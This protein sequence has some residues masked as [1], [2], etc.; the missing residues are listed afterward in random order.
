MIIDDFE[1]AAGSIIGR[2]HLR[3]FGWKNNQD[4]FAIESVSYA[5]ALVVT[6]G[7]GS[8]AKSETGAH[9]GAR[10]VA[11]AMIHAAAS[12]LSTRD[13]PWAEETAFRTEVREIVLREIKRIASAMGEDLRQMIFDHFLFTVN[14]VLVTRWMTMMMSIGDGVAYLNGAA[15]ALGQFESNAPPYLGYTA[16]KPEG[17][18]DPANAF[19]VNAFIPTAEVR[20]ILIGTDGVD[21]LIAA[22]H[23]TLP[24]KSDFVGPISQFWEEDRY[25]ANPDMVRRRLALI[26]NE[27][28]A[29]DW[30][31]RA[32]HRAPGK[33]PDD[34]TL[35]AIRR[36]PKR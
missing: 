29:V 20:S 16:L 31:E 34:T 4:S 21:Y 26:Q 6:D 23:E 35:V 14:A 18:F 12:A 9:I 1:V 22:E 36:K 27:H 7:C 30:R 8:E 33:L 15:L 19:K 13:Y 10:L 3:P 25:F 17:D 2:E 28:L 32:I 5:L 24:G 11:H